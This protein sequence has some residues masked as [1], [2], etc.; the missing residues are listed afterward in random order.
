MSKVNKSE[1][2]W[3]E[4]LNDEEY[5][6]CREKGTECAFTGEYWQCTDDEGTYQCRACREPLFNSETKYDSG[7]GWP[8]FF[9]PTNKEGVTEIE[10]TSLGMTRTEVVCSKCESHLGHVFNDGPEPTGLRYCINSASL[11]FVESK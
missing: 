4:I 3:K 1:E 9:M 10:D 8:S 2:E 11:E 6:I 7:S 5:H